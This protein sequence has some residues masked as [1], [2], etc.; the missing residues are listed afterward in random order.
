MKLNLLL[1]FLTFS[2][3][4]FAQETSI[5]LHS[6]SYPATPIWSFMCDDYVLSGLATVQIAKTEK[7]GLLKISVET[8]NNTFAITS[9]LYVDL[10]DFSAIICTDKGN[11]TIEGN[12]VISYYS[13]TQAEMSR[14]QKVDI[15]AV[16]F[17]IGG[18]KTS[19]SSQTGY[20]TA[21]N[22]KKFFRTAYDGEVKS[23]ETAAAIK[24]LLKR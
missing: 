1:L 4:A 15:E 11:R 18:K 17:F 16:R 13:L 5:T 24:D 6:K 14:L 8:S 9:T 22:K 20:F 21:V 3:S 7:G 10:K 19:F 12:H 2:L 23:H